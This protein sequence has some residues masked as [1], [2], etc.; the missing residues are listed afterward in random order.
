MIIRYYGHS[1]FQ[2]DLKNGSSIAI[3]PY[4]AFQSYPKR[5]IKPDIC[6]ISHAHHDHNGRSSLLP[7]VQI[8]DKPG[9]FH[10][11]IGARIV[12]ISTWHDEAN[13]GKR[14]ANTVFIIETENLRIGHA[15]D[16]GHMPT[17]E[18]MAQI[19]ALD[20]LM[21]P[22][23]GYY[24]IDAQMAKRI[25]QAMKPRVLVPMH[26]KTKYY[27]DYTIEPL[28]AFWMLSARR[29]N[30]LPSLCLMKTG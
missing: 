28:K 8:I 17:Q 13:G 3:D 23:G 18:Q 16:L 20:V 24:T 14:G 4:G 2:I 11:D 15:G 1:F 21:L 5:E 25:Y 27:R 22:V 30:A 26:Y 19:G 7:G 29:M 12:G 6:L 10:T 9:E